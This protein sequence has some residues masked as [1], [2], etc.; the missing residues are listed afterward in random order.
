MLNSRLLVVVLL[1]DSCRLYAMRSYLLKLFMGVPPL[2]RIDREFQAFQPHFPCDG[3]YFD[4][5]PWEKPGVEIPESS[6]KALVGTYCAVH[7]PGYNGNVTIARD[8]TNLTLQCGAHT[9]RLV[10]TETADV[11]LWALE[12]FAINFWVNVWN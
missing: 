7:S 10:A 1:I 8:G 5:V 3:H 6:K 2:A 4:G 9:K 11:F 12:R